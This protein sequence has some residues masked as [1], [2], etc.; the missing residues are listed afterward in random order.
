M[1]KALIGKTVEIEV[2]GRRSD[3]SIAVGPTTAEFKLGEQKVIPGIEAAVGGMEEGQSRTT[4]IPAGKAFG[5]YDSKKTL[6]VQRDR[7]PAGL[8]PRVGLE[9]PLSNSYGESVLAR[10]SEVGDSAAKLDY[11]HPLAGQDL[12]FKI[13]LLK[14]T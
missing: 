11:N 3:G 7:F 8:K 13:R 2:Q 5:E 10:V 9:I 1:T 4:T 14:V 6:R 12:E